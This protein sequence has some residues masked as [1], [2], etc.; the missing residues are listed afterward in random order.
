MGN[1]INREE[2]RQ[3]IAMISNMKSMKLD[4]QRMIDKEGN[5]KDL[6]V[7]DMDQAMILNQKAKDQL[8]MLISV[9]DDEQFDKYKQ[10]L[11]ANKNLTII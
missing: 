2:Y 7:F 11:I 4:T 5:Y 1:T 8:K 6:T 9:R 10:E 3:I